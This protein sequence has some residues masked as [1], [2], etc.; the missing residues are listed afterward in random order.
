ML[1]E[2]LKS[3]IGVALGACAT[4]FFG[5]LSRIGRRIDTREDFAQMLVNLSRQMQY[6]ILNRDMTIS[7]IVLQECTRMAL[8]VPSKSI[9]HDE[10]CNLLGI[11][12]RTYQTKNSDQNNVHPELEERKVAED[13]KYLTLIE[14]RLRKVLDRPVTSVWLEVINELI[15]P[16]INWEKK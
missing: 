14:C 7:E 15:A 11:W 9:L 6:D 13:R 2:I 4:I 8:I 10:F 16:Y 12:R 1:I 3:A 5:I